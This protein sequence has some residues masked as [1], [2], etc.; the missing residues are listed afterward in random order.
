MIPFMTEEIYQN[1][2]RSRG[3]HRPREHAPVRLPRRPTRRSSTRRW[4]TRWKQVLHI[5][6]LGRAARNA[7]NIK[8]RQPIGKMFI[9][10]PK[11][12]DATFTAIITDELNVKEAE[13]T[14]DATAFT[15][16]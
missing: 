1:L 13:F 6:I 7:A 10:A 14:T 3:S 8:N 2:V 5:V 9:G 12:L 4:N 16:L 15:F 11:A